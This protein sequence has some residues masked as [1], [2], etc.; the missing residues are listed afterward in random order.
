[1][2]GT[3]SRPLHLSLI[4]PGKQP[5]RAVDGRSALQQVEVKN[6]GS[7]APRVWRVEVEV[8]GEAGFASEQEF[9]LVVSAV[10]GGRVDIEDG[11]IGCSSLGGRGPTG[12][13]ARQRNPPVVARPASPSDMSLMVL[14]V[15]VLLI[16]LWKGR[17]RFFR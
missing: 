14:P 17:R 5:V 9:S 2:D 16:F 10:G 1:M 8:G 15:L 12:L 6:P 3:M 4:P 7:F 13:T 11:G